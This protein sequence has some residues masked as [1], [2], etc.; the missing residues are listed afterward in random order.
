V[1]LLCAPLAAAT[2]SRLLFNA[3]GIAALRQRVQRPDWPAQ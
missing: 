3:D 2:H 1:A